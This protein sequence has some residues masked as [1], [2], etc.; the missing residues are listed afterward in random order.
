MADS[1]L[2]VLFARPPDRDGGRR[3]SRLAAVAGV[4]LGPDRISAFAAFRPIVLSFS[5]LKMVCC[6]F[7]CRDRATSNGLRVWGL[8]VPR[9]C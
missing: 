6:S 5:V 8:G 4:G 1:T 9:S 3:R 7:S 2:P